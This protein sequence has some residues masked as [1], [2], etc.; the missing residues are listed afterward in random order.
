MGSSDMFA[1]VASN[2]WN[3]SLVIS[4]LPSPTHPSRSNANLVLRK[5]LLGFIQCCQ[6]EC[7]ASCTDNLN[8]LVG[9]FKKPS[10]V[11]FSDVLFNSL[12]Q[13]CYF[14]LW[15][16]RYCTFFFL[17]LCQNSMSTLYLQCISVQTWYI[18]N[19]NCHMWHVTCGCSTEQSRSGQSV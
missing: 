14:N 19:A 10:S 15:S 7:D 1:Y 3:A 13:K 11:N 9:K 12:Y 2:A 16:I 5:S 6:I 17:K 8:F 4:V 18:S